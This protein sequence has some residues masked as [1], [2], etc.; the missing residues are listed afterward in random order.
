MCKIL[1]AV[2]YSF[3]STSSLLH[4]PAFYFVSKNAD[5]KLKNND[6]TVT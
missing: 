4:I 3:D 6:H 1:L 2:T 5:S